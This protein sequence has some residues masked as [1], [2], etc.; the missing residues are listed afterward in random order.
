MRLRIEGRALAVTIGVVAL[1]AVAS[2]LDKKGG[3]GKKGLNHELDLF[4]MTPVEGPKQGGTDVLLVG[5]NFKQDRPIADVLFGTT[6]AASFVVQSNNQIEAVTPTHVLGL[7]D[8]TVRNA[9]GDEATLTD[10]FEFTGPPATCVAIVPDSGAEGGG[11]IVTI[12]TAGFLDDFTAD[13][14]LVFFDADPIFPVTPVDST[15]VQIVTPSSPAPAPLTVDVTVEGTGLPETCTFVDGF[16][17]FPVPP[18][19]PPVCM[20]VVP[21]QGPAA[22]GTNVTITSLGPCPWDVAPPLPTVL[23]GGLAATNV[24]VV[25]QTLLICTTPAFPGGGTVDVEVITSACSCLLPNGFRY[26]D[27]CSITSVSPSSGKTNGG[28]AVL[29]T[30]TDFIENCTKVYF[31]AIEADPALTFADPSGTFID[32]TAPPSRVGG[33]VDVTVELCTGGSCTLVSGFE[34][35]LPGMGACSIASI[36]PNQGPVTGGTSVTISGTGFDSGLG[37]LF[38]NRPATDVVLVSPTQIVA[39]TPIGDGP[40]PVDVTVAPE[41][42]NPCTSRGGFTYQ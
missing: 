36:S 14:P 9:D 13:V 5:F 7:T 20:E 10:G 19:P 28:Y 4:D 15:T 35:I 1:L 40:G 11:D 18:P 21:N 30:G 12:F 31:G 23:F 37:V 6:P 17:Y 29:I 26:T 3:N 8:V 2:C 41:N 38:G 16:T 27:G 25:D 32:L 39:V 42:S 33:F 22:G 24:V 34:Y